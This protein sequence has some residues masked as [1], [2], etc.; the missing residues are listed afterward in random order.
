MDSDRPHAACMPA[1]NHPEHRAD[2]FLAVALCAKYSRIVTNFKEQPNGRI[3]IGS[4]C[5]W[6]NFYNRRITAVAL[7]TT[8]FRLTGIRIVVGFTQVGN[9]RP[10]DNRTSTAGF[11]TLRKRY[12]GQT[13]R[14]Q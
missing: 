13:F 9:P 12:S 7:L 14:E 5:S 10:I 8:G 11:R 1:R 4:G 2:R 3:D 6:R